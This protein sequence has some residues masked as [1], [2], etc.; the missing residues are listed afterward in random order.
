[1]ESTKLFIEL[2]TIQISSGDAI[3]MRALLDFGSQASFITEDVA[4]ALMMATQRSQINVSTMG[5]SHFQN[6]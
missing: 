3:L 1:M 5:F 6:T 4:R 2:V